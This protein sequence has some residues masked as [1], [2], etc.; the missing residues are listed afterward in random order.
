VKVAPLF[1]LIAIMP[2]ALSANPGSASNLRVPLCAGDASG[3]TITLPIPGKA[4]RGP[5]DP[6]CVKACHAGGNRKRIVKDFDTPQ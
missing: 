2:L 3:R 1:A 4:P 6:C 5:N